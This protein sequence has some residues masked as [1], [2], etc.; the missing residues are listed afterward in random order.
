MDVD[1]RPERNWFHDNV[2][3]DNGLQPDPFLAKL[4][5]PGA[6]ILW[7]GSSWTN[8]F[9]QPGASS[10]PPMLP[11]SGWPEFAKKGYWQILEYVTSKLM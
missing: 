8:R 9:D 6:D 5:V 10:F 2:L 4:G 11:S 7:D 1:D 3:A